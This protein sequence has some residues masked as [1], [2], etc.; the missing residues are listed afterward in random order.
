MLQDIGEV[1]ESRKITTKFYSNAHFIHPYLDALLE[2]MR[3]NNIKAT[4]IARVVCP[5]AAYQIP[6]ICTPVEEKRRPVSDF[7]ARTSLQY[8]IAEAA[9]LGKLGAAGYA[10]ESLR[11]PKI[12]ALT[13]RVEY[14]VDETAPGSAH[15]KGWVK[16]ELSDGRKFER[17]VVHTDKP[18]LGEAMQARVRAKFEECAETA[19]WAQAAPKILAEVM[20][21]GKASSLASLMRA[22]TRS[23]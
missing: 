10:E 22:C 7:Q 21:L 8:S 20:T 3:E 19:G 5:I 11:D 17:V 13:D 6:V 14:V 23:A 2:L 15:Y 9:F 4:D 12:L 18:D 1:W 16:L